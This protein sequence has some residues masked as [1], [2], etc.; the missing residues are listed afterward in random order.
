M[1]RLPLIEKASA[2]WDGDR[3]VVLE[4]A[5]KNTGYVWLSTWDSGEDAREFHMAAVWALQ[6]KLKLPLSEDGIADRVVLAEGQ[7]L[8]EHRGA[9]VLI[10]EG[11]SPAAMGKADAF[12]K[13]ARKAEMTGFERLRKFVCAKDGVKEAFSGKCPKCDQPLQFSDEEGKPKKRKEFSVEP[14]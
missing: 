2:G 10:L 12:F 1:L 9:D 4:D 14:R 8:V 6:K 5:A 13:A 11:L 7:A 3:Y